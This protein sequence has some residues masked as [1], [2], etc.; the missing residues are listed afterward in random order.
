MTPID[1]EIEGRADAPDP[2]DAILESARLRAE[3][4]KLR[5]INDVLMD[6]VENDLSAKGHNAFTLFQAAITLENRVA[7]RTAELTH[8]TH[9]LFQQISERRAAEKALLLAKGEAEKANLSKTRFL[10]AASS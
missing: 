3:I 8:L 7:E 10:A 6:R 5:R 2:A 4:E 1:A 9:Q